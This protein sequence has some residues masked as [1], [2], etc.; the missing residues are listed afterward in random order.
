[1]GKKELKDAQRLAQKGDY[2]D[3]GDLYRNSGEHEKA[4][5]MY[6]KARAFNRSA[7]LLEWLG[8]NLEAARHFA[9][10]KQFTKAAELF[11]IAGDYYKAGEM[12]READIP[13]FSAELYEQAGAFSEAAMMYEAARDFFRAG[14]LYVDRGMFGKAVICLEKIIFSDYFDGKC[15]AN[16]VPILKAA[17][18]LCAIAYQKLRKFDKA[19]KCYFDA[20][21]VKDAVRMCRLAG[22]LATGA[23]YLEAK[24]LWSEASALYEEIGEIKKSKRLKIQNLLTSDRFSEA[25]T[26][27]DDSGE[28]LIA[29]EAYE[30]A[31]EF[32]KAAEMYKLMGKHRKAAA[33]Y[34]K[35]NRLLEAAMIYEQIGDLRQAALLREENGEFD[36]AAELYAL[37][38]EPVKSA[39]YYLK[40]KREDDAIRVLQNA[41][42][43]GGKDPAVRNLLGLAFL[44]RGNFDLAFDNYLKFMLEDEVTHENVEIFYELGARFESR[45]QPERA[46]KVFEKISALDLSY[47]DVKRKLLLLSDQVGLRKSQNASQTPVPIHFATGR[48]VADRYEIKE[49]VG[50]G[51]MGVVYRSWDI[52]LETEVALK[53]LKPKYSKDKEMVQRF[54]QEVTLARQIHHDSII[55]VYDIGKYINVL[56]ISMEFFASRDLKALIRSQGP[57]PIDQIIQ[58]ITPVCAGLWAAHCR[59]IV[60][61]DIKPQNVLIND[62]EKVKLVDFGIATMIGPSSLKASEFVIGTPEYMS[63]EQAKGEPA[64]I[65]SDIYSLG[66]ILYEASVG[67]PPFV[68]SDSFQVLVDQVEKPPCPPIEKNQNIPQWLNDLILRCLEKN[69]DK[70]YDSVQVIERQLTTCGLADLMLH[71]GDDDDDDEFI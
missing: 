30:Y 26:L 60:H 3:A 14:Q 62:A 25:A 40:L 56:Y 10:A 71:S 51:G 7:P 50:A 53:V 58:V 16:G 52:E 31:E 24:G 9:K 35:A 19:A 8:R 18:V 55:Q 28:F 27:A 22:D 36:K 54:K 68:N 23:K 45:G 61:R 57:L 21:D 29:A 38:W 5:A 66:T 48:L 13:L 4:L 49:K 20:G 12:Y 63:P 42:S 37:I 65:R 1:M 11:K 70:R 59:G 6:S 41:W 2:I 64:D 39:Q 46:I 15:D 69:P 17:N 32:E 67:V 44:R 43:Q 33:L 34:M 47:K